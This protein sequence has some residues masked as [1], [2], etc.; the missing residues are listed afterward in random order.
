MVN[1]AEE[2]WTF[3]YLFETILTRDTWM[4]RIDTAEATGRPL[5][6]TADHDGV[7]VAD[8]VAEWAAR[9][10]A[11]FALHLTGPAGGTW[12]VGTGGEELEPGRRAASPGRCPAGRRV[13][14]C[15]RSRSRSELSVTRRRR[16]C[17][18]ATVSFS[19]RRVR[20]RPSSTNSAAA[21][22]CPRLAASS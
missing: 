4:H 18:R 15:W 16:R 14:A 11:P 19:I 5:V 22:T 17:G 13:A 21:A 12:S 2:P 9:H 20:C 6:L 10:G 1:G 8:L 3:G 7:L